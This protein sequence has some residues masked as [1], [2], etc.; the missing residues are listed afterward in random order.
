MYTLQKKLIVQGML[1]TIH[2]SIYSLHGQL[3]LWG[4]QLNWNVGGVRLWGH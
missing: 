1:W 2:W 4:L 3:Q